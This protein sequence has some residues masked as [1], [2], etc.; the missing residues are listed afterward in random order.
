VAALPEQLAARGVARADLAAHRDVAH[1]AIDDR[2]G[3]LERPHP[4]PAAV[5]RRPD[6][7]GDI[8]GVA[9]GRRVML[10]DH[11]AGRGRD[12]DLLLPAAA[13]APGDE[14]LVAGDP[15]RGGG[16]ER[17][18]P[19][20]RAGPAGE[21]EHHA[22]QV[23]GVDRVARDHRRGEQLG[24]DRPRPHRRAIGDA[25]RGQLLAA[26]A[27]VRG[28]DQAVGG[29]DLGQRRI[30]DLAQPQPA[31]GPGIEREQRAAL[32]VEQHAAVVVDRG[33]RPVVLELRGRPLD[34]AG[35]GVERVEADRAESTRHVD[36]A[37]AVGDRRQL[38]LIGDPRD[39]AGAILGEP[40]ADRA[41]HR[42]PRHRHG[43]HR[44][45]GGEVEHRGRGGAGARGAVAFRNRNGAGE[46]DTGRRARRRGLGG[47]ARRRPGVAGAAAERACRGGD[48]QRRRD[49]PPREGGGGRPL[50]GAVAGDRRRAQRGHRGADFAGRRG[51]NRDDGG[52]CGR[53]SH[54][55]ASDRWNG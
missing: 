15:R 48:E 17:P 29:R 8:A 54:R 33:G 20:P 32:G 10:A 21:P 44:A 38:E 24:A 13:G 26:G 34:P 12:D 2:P 37:G 14:Q 49:A 25:V 55:A 45:I 39:P 41:A 23:R 43:H 47:G 4:P 19:R 6:L 3:A 51:S 53:R 9:P 40:E 7:A 28:V 22:A 11:R 1:A 30:A 52:G 35:L 5:A 50:R 42:R 18:G 27:G 16:A 36:L 46:V 31:A